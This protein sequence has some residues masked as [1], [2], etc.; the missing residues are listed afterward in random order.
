MRMLMHS[1]LIFWRRQELVCHYAFVCHVSA[2]CLPCVLLLGWRS[3]LLGSTARADTVVS[4]CCVLFK[5]CFLSGGNDENVR[6]VS[7]EHV[8]IVSSVHTQYFTHDEWC[9]VS[10]QCVT[11]H[12]TG[13]TVACSVVRRL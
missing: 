10:R 7:D 9:R 1:C 8:R 11:F 3:V 2:V 6:M 5:H 12:G 13:V 4:Q